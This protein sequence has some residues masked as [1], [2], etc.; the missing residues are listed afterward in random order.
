MSKWSFRLFAFVSA[1]GFVISSQAADRSVAVVD[2][3]PESAGQSGSWT[4]MVHM[5]GDNNL[6]QFTLS[7]INEMERG[8][9]A[10]DAEDLEVIV[11][12]DRSPGYS[13]EWDDWQDARVYRIRHDK[14]DGPGSEVLAQ[15]GEINMGDPANLRDFIGSSVRRFPADHYALIL[16][17]HGGG[18][19]NLSND[20]T[21]AGGGHDYLTLDELALGIKAGLEGTGIDKLDLIGFDMCLMAQLET[22]TA[23]SDVAHYM[24]ASQ[25]IEPGDGWPYTP[26]T[27]LFASR[28]PT[29]MIGSGIVDA[30]DDYYR[31]RNEPIA[32]LSVLDLSETPVLLG[33]L[34]RLLTEIQPK[35]P[36]MWRGLARSFFFSESYI[37]LGDHKRGPNALQSVDLLNTLENLTIVHPEIARGRAWTEFKASMERFVVTRKNSPR[38]QLSSGVAIY[39]PFKQELMNAD[40]AET[41]LGQSTRWVSVLNDLHTRQQNDKFKLD[42]RKILTWSHTSEKEVEDVI[43]L[44]QDGFR[45]DVD[46]SNVLRTLAWRGFTDTTGQLVLFN[47]TT[48]SF[49]EDYQRARTEERSRTDA[50]KGYT[51]PDG[52]SQILDRYDGTRLDVTDGKNTAIA[53]IDNSDIEAHQRGFYF[54]EVIYEHAADGKYEGTMRF[55]WLWNADNLTLAVPQQDGNFSYQSIEPRPDATIT[56]LSERYTN[57]GEIE[58]VS[59]GQLT[60]GQGLSLT[61]TLM[62]PGTYS[63]LFGLEDLAGNLNFKR[64]DFRLSPRR[65]GFTDGL[66]AADLT[67]S[68]LEGVWEV[69]D[70][71]TWFDQRQMVP[72]GG[73]VR[74]SPSQSLAGVL[75]KSVVRSNGEA[76]SPEGL[77]TVLAPSGVPH[78][79]DYVLAADGEP[80]PSWGVRA[81]LPV[82]DHHA[83]KDLLLSMDLSDGALQVMVKNSGPKVQMTKPPQPQQAPG[84]AFSGPQGNAPPMPQQ[85]TLSSPVEGMWAS[86]EGVG[87]QF[88]GNEWAM[89]ENNVMTD[90]GL[91]QIGGNQLQTQSQVTGEVA[92]YLFETNGQMLVVQDAYGTVYQFYRVQ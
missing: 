54:A 18:W 47:K 76:L 14:T 63:T 11:V 9:P 61:M 21:V 45:Y 51:V 57:K 8:F 50:I 83:G 59:T 69:I 80:D 55:N 73:Q 20:D 3:K 52:K 58:K 33:S 92:L 37:E 15:L 43:H 87:L 36:T 17:N 31:R 26:V 75:D 90:R 84:G 81:G 60:W 46:V 89:Y 10:G 41:A 77:V 78:T 25:A 19:S 49:F 86:Y 56:F 72:V 22:A 30:F 91:F 4:V 53:L 88:A 12:V 38:H 27:Q 5:N 1:F 35:M 62:E 23:L 34:D 13:T 67:L 29:A 2:R 48:F 85:Q 79:R 16:W 65:D 44:G 40:Y 32:T 68:N 64:H 7:D 70:A 39:A 71:Q 24:V 28:K 42:I 82:F 66:I 74:Y 6:E